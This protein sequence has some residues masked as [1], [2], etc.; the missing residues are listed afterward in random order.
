MMDEQPPHNLRTANGAETGSGPSGGLRPAFGV[1]AVAELVSELLEATA[2]IPRD[3]LALIRGNAGRGSLAQAL[4]DSG[5][6]GA[7]DLA[8]SLARRHHLPLVD[9]DDV[10]I[11]PSAIEQ[12]PL[13]VLERVVAL[14]YAYE[15]G[16][17]KIAL[18]DPANV[19]GVDELRL[20]AGQPLDL[21]VASRDQI[22]GQLNMLLRASE[23]SKRK[24]VTTSRRTTA[25]RTRRSSGS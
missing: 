2:L 12:V 21:G 23:A 13:H 11:S 8:R 25:S 3:R 10:S 18:A 22:A 1:N 5:T 4:L 14:P 16:R 15:D 19:H 9:L 6:V 17:L 7:D 20:A 24:T